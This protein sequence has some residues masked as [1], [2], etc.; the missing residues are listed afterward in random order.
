[1]SVVVDYET[2]L[3]YN[4]MILTNEYR[5]V[6]PKTVVVTGAVQAAHTCGGIERHEIHILTRISANR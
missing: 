4:A 5:D 6:V 1:M 3:A 2:E